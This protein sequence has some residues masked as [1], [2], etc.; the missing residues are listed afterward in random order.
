MN[1]S[2][3]TRIK[4]EKILRSKKS[5]RLISLTLLLIF[6]NTLIPYNFIYANNNGPT[7]PE[8]SSFEPVDATDMV[9]LGTGD[10]S[11]VLPLLNIP[12][13][14]GGYPVAL[15]YNAGI[16]MG[17]EASWVGLG[18]NLN[19]G[20]INRT[21]S[22]VPDD[23]KREKK[24]SAIFNKGGT[25]KSYTGSV[26]VG[27]NGVFSTGLYASYR[28][29]NSVNGE[30]SKRFDVGH[31]VSAGPLNAQIGTDGA[32]IGIGPVGLN[33][34]F[35]DGSS[36]LSVNSSGVGISLNSK[37]GLSANFGPNSFH[38]SS[39]NSNNKVST[40][41]AS[42]VAYVPLPPAGL[43]NFKFAYKKTKHWLYENDYNEFNGSLYA[44]D[45][46]SSLNDNNFDHKVAFDSYE[47]TENGN[48]SSIENSNYTT[49]GYDNYTVMA[50]GISG[51][52][53]PYI[54]EEGTVQGQ[55]KGMY[56]N[57][58]GY[59]KSDIKYFT[60]QFQQFNNQ[61]SSSVLS[62]D[63]HFYFDNEISSYISS[64]SDYWN[65]PSNNSTYQS[66]SDFQTQNKN[67]SSSLYKNNQTFNGYNSS[68]NRIKKGSYVEV[69]TNKEILASPSLVI[70]PNDFQRN[71]NIPEDGIGAY[72]ITA[73]DGKIYHYSLPVYQRERFSRS[74][75]LEDNIN[76]IFHEE[77]DLSPYAT[78][79]LLTAVTGPDFIDV[80]SNGVPDAND[81]GYWVKFD[82]GK[83]S[84]GFVWRA[85]V[86]GYEVNSTS[87][88]YQW[89]RKEVYYLDKIITRSHTALFVKSPRKD[90]LSSAIN[91]GTAASPVVFPDTHIQSFAQGDDQEWYFNGIFDTFD[92]GYINAYNYAKSEVS[93]YVETRAQKSLRL[94][95]IILLSNDKP[96]VNVSKSNTNQLSPQNLGEISITQKGE[97]YHMT[98]GLRK[99][100]IKTIHDVP[101]WYG[102]FYS[103]V[104][105]SE[106][107]INYPNI[108]NEAIKAIA[109]NYDE[110]YPLGKNS[111]NSIASSKGKLTLK[112]I[113]QLGKGGLNVIPPYNFQYNKTYISNDPQATDDWGYSKLDP[114][115]WSLNEIKTPT[116]GKIGIVY[117][118]DKYYKEAA[119]TN[120]ILDSKFLQARFLGENTGTKYLEIRND[121]NNSISENIDF[122]D[123]FVPYKYIDLD[124][125]FWNNPNGSN[126]HKIAD[127]SNACYVYSVSNDLLKIQ[128]PTSSVS[129][130][131]RRDAGCNDSNWTY[132]SRYNGG[133]GVVQW[134]WKNE[135]GVNDCTDP[136]DANWKFRFDVFSNKIDLNVL[137]GG[138]RVKQLNLTNS[139]NQILSTNYIYTNPSTGLSSGVTSY[140][141][142]KKVKRVKYISALPAPTVMYEFVTV[143]NSLSGQDPLVKT[144]YQFEVIRSM[145]LTTLGFNTGK[146]ISLDKI[147]T[148]DRTI[149]LYGE[150]SNVNFSKNVLLDNSAALGRLVSKKIYNKENTLLESTENIFKD[151]DLID[152][153]KIVET[154]NS[155]K[156]LY[157]DNNYPKYFLSSSQ[158]TK[159]PSV[160]TETNFSSNNFSVSQSINNY[161]FLTGNITERSTENSYGNQ[162]I[163]KVVPAY[164]KFPEMGSKTDNI[165]YKNMLSQPAAEIV[166]IDLNGQLKTLSSN[167]TTWNN[168]WNYY[169]YTGQSSSPTDPAHKIWRK[170][171][172]FIWD[173][174]VSSLDGTLTGYIGDF[175]GFNW[176]LGAAQTNS[177][178]VNTST[179]SLYNHFSKPLEQKDINGNFA[180]TKMGSK[181]SKV[182]SISN[183]PYKSQFYSGA[184]DLISGTQYFGGQ[185]YKGSTAN[186]SNIFHTGSKGLQASTNVKA[187]IV[188]PSSG[189]YRVSVWAYKGGSYNYLGTKLKAGNTILN[190][191]QSEIVIAGDW[192]Q[193]NFSIENLA[194]LQ[195][196]YIYNSSGTAIY[197]DFRV[198]PVQSS[199]GSYVYNGWD[200]LTYILGANN[201]ATKYE[202]DSQGRL[203]RVYKEVVD[204][205]GKTGGFKLGKEIT[206]NHRRTAEMD[207]NGNGYIEQEETYDPLKLLTS[208]GDPS[209][210]STTIYAIA[211]GG[212]G[213]Y[214][215][216]WATGEDANTLS[217]G[218]WTTMDQ[219]FITN[220]CPD[221][222]KYY[223]CLIRDNETLITVEKQSSIFR[224]CSTGG[225]GEP[226]EPTIQ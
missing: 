183:A 43:T 200:E 154:V 69:F 65:L 67:F 11:Y 167:I 95:K 78:H 150:T 159:V 48:K 47:L 74:A 129:N 66:L 80:N 151:P 76:D 208:V 157:K 174:S 71:I 165:I 124:V 193:L 30:N 211:S 101:S 110:S 155:Y 190:Y 128:L 32:G 90:N 111:T 210:Y 160:L 130:D 213:N 209:A 45:I 144:Q 137:G 4:E 20:A 14:E 99:T 133:D 134:G 186:L 140:A 225:G 10:L 73:I 86:S 68:K 8:A 145:S 26:N 212:S 166:Q 156:K 105:D 153:G 49:I 173:G 162:I 215:Y 178:W 117:E 39:S 184:E 146:I 93:F 220:A 192:V 182:Y 92:F 116:G 108:E 7:S 27:W 5:H 148:S 223:K 214:S 82:Y 142:S 44:G 118:Q 51:S 40:A 198:H 54:L 81:Y 135:S 203:H 136:G 77:E 199:I 103:K 9:N 138:I 139:S 180:S 60:P 132:Y 89:G 29:Y 205:S 57:E 24:Y 28:T 36:T 107:L 120:Y 61:L 102:E 41:S 98:T 22:G 187:F 37:H 52:I 12:S 115:A 113:S 1:K 62:Q 53:T 42:F 222:I 13:P 158:R 216:R 171:K 55:Y 181:E 104:L 75:K 123:F 197:D 224:T 131:V 84:D 112:G 91:I 149:N 191:N 177:K 87:K 100:E 179:T 96:S 83:W 189:N 126:S 16:A 221:G 63:I 46:S 207:T 121:P 50:Q 169:D 106:D 141:P 143:E 72:K 35:V 147:Q 79:W 185:V 114:A 218:N 163:S 17:Q 217:Y 34:S 119:I 25:S 31:S 194:D 219:T 59:N 109:F 188:K 64:K 152:Q 58:Q 38:V 125:Q 176:G 164:I 170:H 2:H 168:S 85:P 21:V 97:L 204:D 15:S 6:S 195:E 33:Q 94:D 19:P 127:I 201:M 175:D 70:P 88:S 3:Q 196:V 206:Y 226:L 172:N 161:D 122:N 23:W 202:Y 56:Q 18:W